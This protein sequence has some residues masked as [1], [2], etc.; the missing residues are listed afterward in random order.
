MD[1]NYGLEIQKCKLRGDFGVFFIMKTLLMCPFFVGYSWTLQN[2]LGEDW[3]L[4][5]Y[6]DS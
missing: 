5:Y 2:G 4:Y 6:L 1:L 3:I